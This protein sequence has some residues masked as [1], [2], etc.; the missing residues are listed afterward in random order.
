ML[1]RPAAVQ[2]SRVHGADLAA[3]FR[4]LTSAGR[5]QG[6]QRAISTRE[7]GRSRRVM[8]QRHGTLI[9]ESG[10]GVCALYN[11]ACH[12]DQ[13]LVLP[14]WAITAAALHRNVSCTGTFGLPRSR[15]MKTLSTLWYVSSAL[16]SS[17][18]GC[19]QND[20]TCPLSLDETVDRV[21]ANS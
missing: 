12:I 18:C 15:P 17:H 21:D 13:P 14:V 8:W 10:C 3:F 19:V 20:A 16:A 11:A 7:G 5:S 2:N 9:R 6:G 1:R 4:H